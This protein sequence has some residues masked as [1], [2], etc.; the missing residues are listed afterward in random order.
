MGEKHAEK[1]EREG[2]WTEGEASIIMNPEK[3][4]LCVKEGILVIFRNERKYLKIW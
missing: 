3:Y 1:G 4:Q 2:K